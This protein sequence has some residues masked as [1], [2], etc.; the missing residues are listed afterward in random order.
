MLVYTVIILS[1]VSAVCY[2]YVWRVFCFPNGTIANTFLVPLV[3]KTLLSKPSLLLL[4]FLH[5][6]FRPLSQPTI[7][8]F[9]SA[10]DPQSFVLLQCVSQIKKKVAP[11]LRVKLCI[12]PLE[13]LTWS[14]A[15]IQ[16]LTWV[17]NDSIEFSTFYS[18]LEIDNKIPASDKFLSTT[19]ALLNLQLSPTNLGD[20][21]LIS[22]ATKLMSMIWSKSSNNSPQTIEGNIISSEVWQ[23]QLRKNKAY[24]NSCRYYGPGV[25]YLEGEIYPPRRLHHLERRLRSIDMDSLLPPDGPPLLFGGMLDG[26]SPPQPPER[27]STASPP[28]VVLYYSFR[29]PY[30]QLAIMRLR[31]LC[32]R[33]RAVLVLKVMM[34]M[35]LRGLVVSR[36]LC[37]CVIP[38]ISLKSTVHRCPITRRSTSLAMQYGRDDCTGTT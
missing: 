19:I 4:R 21:E 11:E 25:C 7:T 34:P 9:I 30:S 15:Y 20:E 12:L 1:V 3:L 8:L 22:R 13:T 2:Y 27:A 38:V 29:S 37:S 23:E 10:D 18:L 33:Y 36:G 35:V 5:S 26:A 6:L 31:K 24:L 28:E 14:T 17:L 32:E 16:Q